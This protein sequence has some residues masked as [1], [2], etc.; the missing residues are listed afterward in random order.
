MADSGI[1]TGSFSHILLE[2]TGNI[3]ESNCKQC[4]EYVLQLNEALDE[5]DSARKIIEILQKELSIYPTSNNVGGNDSASAKASSK[6]VAETEWTLVPARN[7]SSN[8]NISDKHKVVTSDQFI[9]TAN[10]FSMPPNL[11][12]ADSEGTIPVIVNGVSATKGSIKKVGKATPVK[13]AYNHLSKPRKNKNKILIIGDS[14]ARGCAA[15]LAS[16]L[17]KTF[18]VTGT[19]I[20]CS[21]LDNITSVARR[22]INT[23]CQ[24]DFLVIWGG[25]NDISKNESD[26]GLRYEETCTPKQIYKHHRSNSITQI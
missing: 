16:S 3:H 11:V 20:P 22:E 19:V 7:Y 14:Q 25:T 23:L 10:R 26:V 9:K 17:S 1:H 18:E 5:L 21:R 15:N 12:S 24:N 2:N 13:T 8:P 6:P 4:S